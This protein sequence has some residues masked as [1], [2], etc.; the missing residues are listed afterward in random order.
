MIYLIQ[1][2]WINYIFRERLLRP[3]ISLSQLDIDHIP[4]IPDIEDLQDDQALDETV[5]TNEESV[6]R[7]SNNTHNAL[8]TD[9]FKQ[10]AFAFLDDIELSILT[11]CL[12]NEKDLVEQDDIW[13]WD[14]LFTEVS[15][16][17]HADKP[18]SADASSSQFVH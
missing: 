9:V 15:G 10:G 7:R 13:T 6:N 1:L 11:R 18:K 5:E 17:I 2:Y 4:V 16:D 3:S 14:K 12:L 8:N